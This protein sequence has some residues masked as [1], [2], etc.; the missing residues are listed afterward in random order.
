MLTTYQNDIYGKLTGIQSFSGNTSIITRDVCSCC[1]WIRM[2]NLFQTV[3]KISESEVFWTLTGKVITYSTSTRLVTTTLIPFWPLTFDL[4]RLVWLQV[5]MPGEA[6][7]EGRGVRGG[8]EEE[9]GVCRHGPGVGVHR[10]DA[11][12]LSS[13]VAMAP[14]NYGLQ[15]GTL[16][17]FAQRRSASLSLSRS[18]SAQR[19]SASLSLSLPLFFRPKEVCFLVF[20][21][22]MDQLVCFY[23]SLSPSLFPLFLSLSLS[24]CLSAVFFSLRAMLIW[25]T[26][27]IKISIK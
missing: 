15:L 6:V 23:L 3:P 2:L 24:L 11:V 22:E 5:A 17:A 14:A 7:R 8:P 1:V 12:R 21:E 27:A 26:T 19:R 9:P 13:A 10:G 20:R 18:L 4:L 25:D 16:P